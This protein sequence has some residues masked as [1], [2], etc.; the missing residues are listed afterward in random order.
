MW[1]SAEVDCVATCGLVEVLAV[2][3]EVGLAIETKL[4]AG[5]D[6]EVVGLV[7]RVSVSVGVLGLLIS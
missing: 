1:L 7:G 6:V 3:G 2:V 5:V 4:G